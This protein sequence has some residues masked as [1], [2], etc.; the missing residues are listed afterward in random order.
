LNF[1]LHQTEWWAPMRTRRIRAAAAGALR[2]IGT[3]AALDV[4]RAAASRG[5]RGVRA[6][7]RA[8]LASVAAS[9]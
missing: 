4:L 2:Q 6:A 9:D 5:P 7:A 3:P 1:A 8:Q